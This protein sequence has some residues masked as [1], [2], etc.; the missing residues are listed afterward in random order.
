MNLTLSLNLYLTNTYICLRLDRSLYLVDRFG[1]ILLRQCIFVVSDLCPVADLI[2]IYIHTGNLPF[3][4]T[5]PRVM[6]LLYGR[7]KSLW[8]TWDIS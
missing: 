8:F 2:Y 6:L 5:A 3:T 4:Q 7:V 1:W